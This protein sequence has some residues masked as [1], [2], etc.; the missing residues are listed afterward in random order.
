MIP[1]P[2]GILDEA[3]S[4]EPKPNGAGGPFAQRYSPP[5]TPAGSDLQPALPP[6]WPTPTS[7]PASGIPDISSFGRS[8]DRV[9]TADRIEP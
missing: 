6:I 3:F 2:S 9:T 1:L 4:A 5:S 7:C 8:I